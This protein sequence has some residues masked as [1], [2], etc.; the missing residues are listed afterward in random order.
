MPDPRHPNRND[1]VPDAAREAQDVLRALIGRDGASSAPPQ[2][3][4]PMGAEEPAAMSREQLIKAE[5]RYRALVEQLPAI[6]FAAA[7]DDTLQE[8]YVSP[9]I[10]AILGFS[11]KEW[12]E[13]PILWYS[14]LH[15]DDRHRWQAEFA[16][17]IVSATPF[18]AEY[19]FL[20]RDG[21]VVWVR[22]EAQVIRDPEGNPLFLQGIA[23]D[24]TDQK[25]ADAALRKS[26]EDLEQEVRNRT[27]EL[28]ASN[29][30]LHEEIAERQR[31]EH[32]LRDREARLRSIVETAVDGIVLINEQG[33]IESFNRA[34]E[35]IFG[36]PAAEVM[37]RNVSMLMPPPY[38]D[39]H[40]QYL[41]SYRDTGIRKVIGLGRDVVGRRKDG[42]EFPMELAVSETPTNEG[43]KF[44]G[45]VRDVTERKLAE[46]ALIEAKRAAEAAS[47]LKGEFL[48][49]M[50]HEIRIP[51]N[52]ILGMT[53]LA[54]DTE[55][56]PD[57]REYLE[58]VKSSADAL[59]M[60]INDILDFTK[61]E[62][63]KMDLEAIDLDLHDVLAESLKSL[64]VRAQ[65]K[66]VELACEID[67][68]VP[69]ILVG[70]PGRLRQIVI[71][72]VGNAVKFTEKGE[73][74][75]SVKL[76]PA[77]EGAAP[78]VRFSVR[79]TGIGIPADK[80]GVIFESFTQADGTTTRK[81]GGTGLGLAICRK[82]VRMM[83]GT[84]WL[85]SE[86]GRGTTIHFTAALPRSTTP[87]PSTP[88]AV[89]ALAGMKALIV[90]DNR[91]NRAILRETVI[92]WGMVPTLCA[93]GPEALE[94]MTQAAAD[95]QPFSVVLLDAMMPEMDGFDV[96][97]RIHDDPGL[98]G[99]TILMLSSAAQ[100]SDVAASRELGLG[101]FLIKPVGRSDLLSAIQRTLGA[102]NPARGE[103]PAAA[104]VEPDPARSLAILLAED[105][106]VNQRLAVR[107]LHKHGHCAVVAENGQ[108][109]I[110]MLTDVHFDLILMD[111]QMP[112]LD[113]FEATRLIRDRE[114]LTGR[115]IPI[116]ALT[117]NAMKGDRED[118]L[119]AGFDDY[120]SKPIRWPELSEAIRLQMR[121][122]PGPP[123]R[124][125][126][127]EAEAE[128]V[129]R[130]DEAMSILGGDAELLREIADLFLEGCP[131]M[132]AELND[133]IA[134]GD[135]R[136]AKRAAHTIR[137]VV[138]NF[139]ADLAVESVEAI[140]AM[141]VRADP[142]ATVAA[143]K[144]LK[145]RLETLQA[146]LSSLV[147]SGKTAKV[148]PEGHSG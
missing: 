83:G 119:E 136:G 48:A 11:Q 127:P 114:R 85:E 32:A 22:G 107:L 59:L 57:Q 45:I 147:L 109:A 103:P 89:V 37:G 120:V 40:D 53:E 88:P 56:K 50:S 140:E 97:R 138:A 90:D 71:N 124:E 130:E 46:A 117:A 3:Y 146:E 36:Y 16:Q 28:H 61:I 141:D 144:V 143:F 80:Q 68:E 54:L 106:P 26:R 98:V 62:A 63:G 139:G 128:A 108:V 104:D 75:V 10:E 12:L 31:A 79:D 92:G 66:G 51:M 118:C 121:R 30:S 148:G 33:V 137:G 23:F 87:A 13:N 38:R 74:V 112:V 133:A 47:K 44:T 96:I 78:L 1:D 19:R 64:A 95:G 81:F 94:A 73:V 110:E 41:Q 20:A 25:L 111:V 129:F 76:E 8:L 58:T 43:L 42:S 86:F 7:M 101:A 105:N 17:T 39:E 5:M 49:N 34:A 142:G 93:S 82:L 60:L 145:S 27:A 122:Y 134:R 2:A 29:Q 91:T 55:L 131:A 72:L 24:I 99:A 14:Q 52:G 84:I 135:D 69:E 6:T 70:D 18:R 102:R 65:E 126:E 125:P 77:P 15:P 115:H 123:G 132:L 116:I 35:R 100:L 4:T 21:R 67:P 9:Q 113:G